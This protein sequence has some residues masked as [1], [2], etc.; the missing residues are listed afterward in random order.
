MYSDELTVSVLP[1]PDP[2]TLDVALQLAV[3]TTES[4]HR[5]LD[6]DPVARQ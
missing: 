4:V 3:S 1:P 5:F 2:T 6:T